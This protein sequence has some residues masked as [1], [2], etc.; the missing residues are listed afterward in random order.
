[1]QGK[2]IMKRTANSPDNFIN[3]RPP[4]TWWRGFRNVFYLFSSVWIPPCG[5]F[6]LAIMEH[7]ETVSIPF[8]ISAYFFF[9]LL[10]I[11]SVESVIW[12]VKYSLSMLILTALILAIVFSIVGYFDAPLLFLIVSVI[13][14]T[15]SAIDILTLD[16]PVYLKIFLVIMAFPFAAFAVF[17][18]G[19]AAA[20]QI[21]H[22]HF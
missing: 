15:I 22:S 13:F 4:L 2:R 16:M 19:W 18:F 11:A 20:D 21:S 17:I 8:L 5:L 1:M 7:R 3:I 10:I 14:L 6:S 9:L 12:F